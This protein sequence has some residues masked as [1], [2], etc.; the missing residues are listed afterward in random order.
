MKGSEIL[1]G[2]PQAPGP[3][4]ERLLLGALD[5]ALHD[6][7]ALEIRVGSR[8]V[9]ALVSRL[10]L[11]L[12]EPGDFFFPNLT[13]RSLAAAADRLGARLL[14]PLLSD[15]IWQ[16]A[17]HRLRP[18]TQTPDALMAYTTRMRLHSKAVEAQ[19]PRAPWTGLVAGGGK[20][21]VLTNVL[22][23]G[24]AA[25]YGWHVQTSP[26]AAVTPGL[27]VLQPLATA[28]NLEHVD[29][30]Q[31]CRFLSRAATVDGAERDVDEVLRDPELW[32]A[33]SHEGPVRHLD[34]RDVTADTDPA[35]TEPAPRP[36]EPAAGDIEGVPLIQARNYTPSAR[37][38]A[39]TI[40][41]HTMEAAEKPKTARAVASWFAGPNAPRASAHFCVDAAET[42]QCVRLRDVAWHAPG[43]NANGIGVEHAGYARQTEAQWADAYSFDALTRS[44]RLV[45]ELCR[46]FAIPVQRLSV[47]DLKAGKRGIC[48]HHDVSKAFRKS[49]HYDPGPHFP[50]ARYLD[51]IRG[52]P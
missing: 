24:R 52:A 48:G 34:P 15:L 14:T 31:T 10:P 7:H 45:A 2:L 26:Y 41:I 36:A 35:P 43:A 32:R 8:S 47:E 37:T 12:G 13:C 39:T 46:R 11:A 23:K 33:L 50:W 40:V 18:A 20:D 21:W 6:W 44:A 27:R 4:R 49:D 17:D 22:R 19:L 38:G 9:V 30:S 28:H 51:L 42:I 16:R 5:S 29:Y 3:D 25:N 1:S